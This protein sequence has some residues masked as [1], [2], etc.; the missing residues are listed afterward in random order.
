MCIFAN[1][2]EEA[3]MTM[4]KSK[5]TLQGNMVSVIWYQIFGIG[6][7]GKVKTL[8]CW[9]IWYRRVDYVLPSQGA[10]QC[11]QGLVEEK[12]I[13]GRHFEWRRHQ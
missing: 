1:M 13:K 8:P 12:A 11:W 10:T 6:D 3:A 5:G 4:K 2:T 9:E 7:D